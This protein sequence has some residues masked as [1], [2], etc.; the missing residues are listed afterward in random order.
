MVLCGVSPGLALKPYSQLSCI[1]R[2]SMAD[3][4]WIEKRSGSGSVSESAFKRF[5]PDTDTDPD[6]LCHLTYELISNC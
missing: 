6:G 4:Y 3:G 2:T 5:D 1:F